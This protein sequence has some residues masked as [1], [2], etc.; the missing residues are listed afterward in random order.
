MQFNADF[1]LVEEEVENY[2][3]ELHSAKA[4]LFKNG[5]G[6]VKGLVDVPVLADGSTVGEFLIETPPISPVHGSFW[7][8]PLGSS[9]EVLSVNTKTSF[10]SLKRKCES[11]WDLLAVNIGN[12]VD[13]YVKDNDQIEK[14]TGELV[15]V[16]K[17]KVQRSLDSP[18]VFL[19]AHS[20]GLV[21]LNT[22]KTTLALPLSS[23]KRVEC[24]GDLKTEGFTQQEKGNTLQIKYSQT[25]T[26]E[27]GHHSVAITYLTRG[28]TWAPSYKLIIDEGDDKT[29]SLKAKAV[30]LNDKETLELS[31]LACVAGFPHIMFENTET[32]LS[33]KDSVDAFLRSLS[34]G[35]TTPTRS[36]VTSNRMVMQQQVMSN[37]ASNSFDVSNTSSMQTSDAEDHHYYEW[38]DVLLTH[39]ERVYL[40]M[41]DSSFEYSDVYRCDIDGNQSGV[42][43]YNGEDDDLQDVWHAVQF[44]NNTDLT[45]TTAPVVSFKGQKFVS[46]D[47]V[48]Y[49]PPGETSTINLTKALNVKVVF[50]E[51]T[52]NKQSSNSRSLVTIMG[53]NYQRYTINGKLALLNYK[54]ETV[55]I[56]IKIENMQGDLESATMEPISNVEKPRRDVTNAQRSVCW[57][58]DVEPGQTIEIGFTRTILKYR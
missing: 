51:E 10:K 19:N 21:L 18:P 15:S 11:I 56:K 57:E 7:V 5:V 22:S 39:Q 2:P 3:L 42:N 27:E 37:F 41:F 33:K 13:L 14:V 34:S 8:E 23:I 16:P 32:P 40:P 46:Q 48:K 6:M 55:T 45:W 17:Q 58:T 26:P 20:P 52:D 35:G 28:L 36:R 25:E 49:T 53:N 44:K 43:N 47:M 31:E 30:I 1:T 24:K 9:C 38:K 12:E 50:K 29:A 54:S 4:V